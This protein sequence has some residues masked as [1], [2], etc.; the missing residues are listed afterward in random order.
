MIWVK[1]VPVNEGEHGFL[2]EVGLSTCDSTQVCKT[3]PV[4]QLWKRPLPVKSKSGSG[5][6]SPSPL[7]GTRSFC[8]HCQK[9]ARSCRVPVWSSAHTGH[10]PEQENVLSVAPRNAET[11]RGRLEPCF[12]PGTLQGIAQGPSPAEPEPAA[13]LRA[14]EPSRAP[15]GAAAAPG[16]D[17]QP[18][19]STP[20]PP[21]GCR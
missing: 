18:S 6:L 3:N 1:T 20:K 11:T 21:L 19:T 4:S 14:A 7:D 13:P 16:S 9:P 8:L 17:A 10:V 15:Q 5:E 12:L 2:R